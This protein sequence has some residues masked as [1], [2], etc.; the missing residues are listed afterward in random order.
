MNTPLRRRKNGLTWIASTDNVGVIG[1]KVYRNGAQIDTSSTTLYNDTGLSP[2]TTYT[3]T[4]VAYDAAGNPSAQSSPASATTSDTAA[5]SVPTGLSATAVS[6]FQIDLT[7]NA[8]TDN[9]GV[10]GYNIYRNGSSSPISTSSTTLYNDTGLTPSTIY[11]YTVT[12]YDA[13]G[14]PSAQSSP[15]SATTP[16]LPAVDDYLWVANYGSNT[17]TRILKSNTAISTTITVGS[18][19]VGLAVD[20]D[21][22]WVANSGSDYGVGFGNR[23]TR[24]KK[25]DLTTTRIA[26]E[27]EPYGVAVD[28][29]YVWVVNSRINPGVTRINKSDLTTTMGV[30]MGTG[31]YSLGDMTGYAYD[32]IPP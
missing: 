10:T 23:V 22:V 3:Y 15:I 19:P 5:P 1:Y 7:W 11:T 21:Y 29:T 4:V 26:V 30:T 13:A 16:A 12:A 17:V 6:P 18:T 24:I 32:N 25:S 14:N 31:T 27:S 9:V 8:S 28:D 20:S 2:S